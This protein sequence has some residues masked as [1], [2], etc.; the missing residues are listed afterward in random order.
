MV[1]ATGD[2]LRGNAA[3]VSGAAGNDDPH[4]SLRRT[5]RPVAL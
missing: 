3:D 2:S 5:C 1:A 4:C